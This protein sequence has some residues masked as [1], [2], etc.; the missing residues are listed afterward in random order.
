MWSPDADF[1]WASRLSH[2]TRVSCVEPR[3]WTS[4][5][6]ILSLSSRYWIYVLLFAVRYSSDPLSKRCH[7]GYMGGA[8]PNIAFGL[9]NTTSV[10]TERNRE[11][12]TKLSMASM[13]TLWK[14]LSD[15]RFES[16][17]RTL[18]RKLDFFFGD[19]IK[20]DEEILNNGNYKWLR[21]IGDQRFFLPNMERMF[22]LSYLQSM[23]VR[24]LMDWELTK[25]LLS[26]SLGKIGNNTAYPAGHNREMARLQPGLVRK[27]P[28]EETPQRVATFFNWFM[29]A[30]GDF[31][32]SEFHVIG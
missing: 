24:W 31:L 17:T 12:Q 2:W 11:W 3:I 28:T 25:S 30:K 26:S 15:R 21:Q 22:P 9:Q 4:T 7:F 10:F 16:D 27:Y 29:A 8:D 14:L 20:E 32:S 23:F 19:L 1:M 18:L 13:L 5:L 6:G